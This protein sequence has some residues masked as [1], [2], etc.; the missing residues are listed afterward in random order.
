MPNDA[1]FEHRLTAVPDSVDE[2]QA[3][4]KLGLGDD[5]E[6]LALDGLTHVGLRTT[7]ALPIQLRH[8][9]SVEREILREV[10]CPINQA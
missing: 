1:I 5:L 10:P 2:A 9:H 8:G 6:R 3:L 7:L 4:P